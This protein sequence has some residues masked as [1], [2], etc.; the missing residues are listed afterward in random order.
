MP[1]GG[2]S[3]CFCVK[4][5]LNYYLCICDFYHLSSVY[6]DELLIV[7][8][9]FQRMCAH[10]RLCVNVV[11]PL[12]TY[13]TKKKINQWYKI[14]RI[15]KVNSNLYV[16]EIHSSY[17]IFIFKNRRF[18]MLHIGNIYINDLNHLAFVESHL[19]REINIF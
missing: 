8:L 12:V 3:I 2:G 11:T 16:K 4:H 6:S 7:F 18:H 9:L 13:C 17:Q 1:E 14:I 5:N 15:T 10:V 19:H